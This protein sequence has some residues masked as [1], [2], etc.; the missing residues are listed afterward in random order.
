MKKFDNTELL[1]KKEAHKLKHGND[2]PWVDCPWDDPFDD[3]ESRCCTSS[4]VRDYVKKHP[5]YKEIYIEKTRAS[6]KRIKKQKKLGKQM[7]M[8][9]GPGAHHTP[10]ITIHCYVHV[11]DS[12]PSSVTNAHITENINAMSSHFASPGPFS[13]WSASAH[14]TGISFA[15][16]PSCR[17]DVTTNT[18]WPYG[19]YVKQSSSGGSDP[20]DPD[21][22]LN[23]WICSLNGLLGFATFPWMSDVQ[24]CVVEKASLLP[25]HAGNWPYNQNK[26][27]THEVGHF[28]NLWHIWGDADCNNCAN[29]HPGDDELTD[30][31]QQASPNFGCPVTGHDTCPDCPGVD[32]FE[33]YMDYTD[34]GCMGMFTEDQTDR[35]RDCIA[36][37]RPE[38]LNGTATCGSA[39]TTT[40]S[41]TSSPTEAGKLQWPTDE[42]HN[43][44]TFVDPDWTGGGDD[45]YTSH[46]GTDIGFHCCPID[47]NDMVS[48]PVPVYAA[49]SGTVV[50]VENAMDDQCDVRLSPNSGPHS[51]GGTGCNTLS[52]THPISNN[53]VIDHGVS[54]TTPSYRYTGYYHLQK[55]SVPSILTV[56]STVSKGDLIGYVGSSGISTGPHL[57]FHVSNTIVIGNGTGGTTNGQ[58]IVSDSVDPFLSINSQGGSNTTGSLWMD[59]CSLPIYNSNTPSGN[60]PPKYNNTDGTCDT[61]ATTTTT[62]IDPGI[63]PTTSDPGTILPGGGLNTDSLECVKTKGVEIQRE[64]ISEGA[65]LKT[66]ITTSL[67]VFFIEGISKDSVKHWIDDVNHF[68][69]IGDVLSSLTI[70]PVTF[71]NCRITKTSYPTAQGA[72]TDAAHRGSYNL[73]IQEVVN[74]NIFTS[75]D[76]YSLDEKILE[77]VSETISYSVGQGNQYSVTHNVSVTPNEWMPDTITPAVAAKTLLDSWSPATTNLT[78]NSLHDVYRA[79]GS[80]GDVS[81]TYNQITGQ[82]NWTRVI[83]TLSSETSGKMTLDQSHS[84]VLNK[85][86]IITVTETGKMKLIK[87]SDSYSGIGEDATEIAPDAL[88]K[89][90]ASFTNCE[91]MFNDSI[92]AGILGSSVPSTVPA[93][94][95]TAIETVKTVN[96]ISQEL[97]YSVTYTND[98]KLEDDGKIIDRSVN[99]TQDGRGIVNIDEKNSSLWPGAKQSGAGGGGGGIP[100][101]V[102]WYKTDS[103]GGS[104]RVVAYWATWDQ[105]FNGHHNGGFTFTEF[106]RTLNY[107]P[108]GKTFSYNLVFTSDSSFLDPTSSGASLGI[109]KLESKTSDKLP[110]KMMKEYPI[111]GL[112]M[113]VHNP[114]QSNLG[115]RS[116]SFTAF[117]DRKIF[118]YLGPIPVETH[119]YAPSILVRNYLVDLAKTELLNVFTE[120]SLIPDDIF[121]TDCTWSINSQRQITLNATA[122][123]VQ[124]V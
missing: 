55:N 114:N 24:G 98:P 32:M 67:E 86:G 85:E 82:A 28:L 35:M 34:D 23:I 68:S 60:V 37:D 3:S 17:T 50:W 4:Y 112:T 29:T 124:A 69:K 100:Y 72:M 11:L 101:G 47:W 43:I 56:N 78:H 10:N 1:K 61:V 103:A 106:R 39:A 49:E 76:P 36:Q 73:T 40:T 87:T 80:S 123:Y 41:T 97:N 81:S 96:L 66:V 74:G 84:L 105:G 116:V 59:Q 63:T 113:M 107:N 99:I 15:W 95:N 77:N 57:H 30:T 89:I 7:G 117:L 52:G 110:Q 94:R 19:N 119:S 102:D 65:L 20:V 79:A 90:A 88:T 51:P 45:D 13:S 5:E 9:Y 75:S 71:G 8:V 118:D 64:Y 18:V 83:N 21:T 26:T 48:N 42:G 121:V 22:K 27:M 108:D 53:V 120:Q 104:A 12:N 14:D 33:N 44:I 25:P 111:P 54:S 115:S 93:L 6:V 38:L 31:P 91:R 2:V 58:I 70:G 46:G 122:Q 109:K 62:T 92:G 16:D